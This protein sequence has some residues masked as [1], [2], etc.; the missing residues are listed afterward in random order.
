MPIKSLGRVAFS[1][2][3]LLVALMIIGT[4][5]AVAMPKAADIITQ[6]KVQ[7]AAQ[8]VQIDVQQ[9]YSIASRNRKPVKLRWSST[10]LQF[11]VTDRAETKIYRRTGVG[12]GAGYNLAASD[13]VVY[14]NPLTVFPNGLALDTLYIKLSKGNYS[15]TIRV[16]KSG[17][18]RVQ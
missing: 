17:M 7:R 6:T 3:E 4:V 18:I 2:I 16:S 8:A 5:A 1:L 13:V 15:R 9:A 11:Q 14:P 10:D 12:A